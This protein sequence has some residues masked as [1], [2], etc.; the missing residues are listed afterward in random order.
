MR[1][2]SGIEETLRL[3]LHSFHESIPIATRS[4]S[5]NLAGRVVELF[6]VHIIGYSL[7]FFVINVLQVFEPNTL[8]SLVHGHER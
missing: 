4:G 5:R 3:M 7:Q 2:F 1:C 8:C 6:V